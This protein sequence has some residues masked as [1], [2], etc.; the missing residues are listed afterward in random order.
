MK[1]STKT[2]PIRH[3]FVEEIPRSFDPDVLYISIRFHTTAHLCFCGCGKEVIA[4]LSPARWQ[5]TYDGE[6]VSLNPSIGNWNL[7]C[8]SHYWIHQDRVEWSYDY[9]PGEIAA[10]QRH[11]ERRLAEKYGTSRPSRTAAKKE[12]TGR[13]QSRR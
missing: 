4:P 1:S 8:R 3:E 10:A 2:K 5:L 12:G 7:P 13:K 11:L 9:T 6:T